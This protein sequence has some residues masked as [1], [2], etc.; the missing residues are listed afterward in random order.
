MREE[1]AFGVLTALV[2]WVIVAMGLA[3]RVADIAAAWSSFSL[4]VRAEVVRLLLV[5]GLGMAAA[6][7]IAPGLAGMVEA[8]LRRRARLLQRKAMARDIEDYLAAAMAWRWTKEALT[9]L[10][11]QSVA[12]N[13]RDARHLVEAKVVEQIGWTAEERYAVYRL[14]GFARAIVRSTLASATPRAEPPSSTASGQRSASWPASCGSKSA[15]QQSYTS[16]RRAPARPAGSPT[17][18]RRRSSTG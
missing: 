13:E 1:T 10:V 18:S 5:A 9:L 15:S 7:L 3:G 6:A 17:S 16:R 8:M 2:T 14:T 12:L 4:F 11:K